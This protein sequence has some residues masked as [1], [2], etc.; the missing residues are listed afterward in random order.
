[1]I[2]NM[3]GFCCPD[4]NRITWIFGHW[5]RHGRGR[6]DRQGTIPRRNTARH[7]YPRIFGA[8]AARSSPSNTDGPHAKLYVRIARDLWS[9]VS[10]GEA[11]K[12]APRIVIE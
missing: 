10:T 12:P 4:C 1:V 11:S 8:R 2:E 7:E 3:S 6:E 5:R 9:A